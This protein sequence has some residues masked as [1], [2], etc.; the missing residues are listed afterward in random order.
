MKEPSLRASRLA[1]AG[2][3]VGI[4]LVGGAGFLLGRN[5]SG[6][7]QVPAAP[8]APV[9]QPVVAPADP[10]PNVLDRAGLIALAAA[11]VDAEAAGAPLPERVIQSDGR[12]FLVN[13]PFG[14]GGPAPA[15]SEAP[16]RWRIDAK[17]LR[18]HVEPISL[19]VMDWLQPAPGEVEAAA[20]AYWIARPWTSSESCPAH[21]VGQEGLDAPVPE[22]TLALAQFH[23]VEGRRQGRR[24]GQPLETVQ[25]VTGEMPD[26]SQGLR[27]R[28]SGR[29]GNVPG[30]N[31]PV[32]CRR[33]A[34]A[35]QRPVCLISIVTDEM[36]IVNPAT[37]ETLATWSVDRAD[38]VGRRGD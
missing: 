7:D 11:A 33:P 38:A 35:G 12:R 19:P 26:L 17:A 32:L 31:S 18:I 22:E 10:K 30:R 5:T 28:I 37:G 36:A 6:R 21:A 27:L 1:I 29:I 15:A 4:L 20:E 24:A 8:P 9:P 25:R 3:I 13:L 16:M 34:D 23:L 14:C 2:S